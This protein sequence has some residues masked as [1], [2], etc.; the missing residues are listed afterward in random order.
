MKVV[1]SK[2]MVAELT[3]SISPSARKPRLIAEALIA[4]NFPVVFVE[5][6]PATSE[7]LERVHDPHF[8]RQILAG[9]I[10][11]GFGTRSQQVINSLPYTVGSMINASSIALKEGVCAALSSGF[12]HASYAKAEAFCTFN[13]LMAAACHLL[14]HCMVKKVCIIDGDQHYGNGTDDIIQKLGISQV[15]NITFGARYTMPEHREAY[16]L[17]V[18]GLESRLQ[19]ERPDIILYQAGADVHCQDPLGGVLTT[20]DMIERDVIIFNMAK[21]LGV[22]I[23]WNLA[24]GY[25]R[26]ASG[27]IAKVIELHLNTFRAAFKVFEP[28]TN[29]MTQLNFRS[30][31]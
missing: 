4:R 21:T 19:C 13:G 23:V 28:Q 11:N 1:Y 30:D 24:G 10:P 22:P 25:R 18:R 17:E 29:G 5:P 31:F 2:Q 9:R 3:H 26:D 20:M 12:H 16:L 27:G 15:M 6:A 14:F 8:V 7:D